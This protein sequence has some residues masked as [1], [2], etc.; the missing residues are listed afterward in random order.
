MNKDYEPYPELCADIAMVNKWV[1]TPAFLR[2][3][4]QVDEQMLNHHPSKHL[5]VHY[6]KP[7]DA[8]DRV[9]WEIIMEE[10]IYIKDQEMTFLYSIF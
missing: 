10:V 6:E 3:A 1:T 7:S 5:I 2:L 9:L 8:K 4:I